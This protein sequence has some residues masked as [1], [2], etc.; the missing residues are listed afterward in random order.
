MSYS[1]S[2][3]LDHVD[4]CL[5]FAKALHESYPQAR[6]RG[7]R[8]ISESVTV[9][10]CDVIEIEAAPKTDGVRLQTLHVYCGK[11]FAGGIVWAGAWELTPRAIIPYLTPELSKGKDDVLRKALLAWMAGKP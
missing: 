10:E 3:H 6:R 7:D 8:W 4:G 11:S 1:P 5:V 2:E 9:E